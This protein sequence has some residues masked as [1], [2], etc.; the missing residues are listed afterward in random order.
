MDDLQYLKNATARE[1]A[2]MFSPDFGKG[3]RIEDFLEGDWD[4][5]HLIG[6]LQSYAE[7]VSEPEDKLNA[8]TAIRAIDRAVLTTQQLAD[9]REIMFNGYSA[10]HS[11]DGP[12]AKP[13]GQ[14]LKQ[15]EQYFIVAKHLAQKIR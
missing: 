14:N 8:S 7:A 15:S 6:L 13:N 10:R 11:N 1:M 3:S 5:E 9:L 12:Y 2:N 4:P